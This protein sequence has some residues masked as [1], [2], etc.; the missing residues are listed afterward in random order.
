VN[1]LVKVRI[2]NRWAWEAK[3]SDY[4]YHCYPQEQGH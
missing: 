4:V 2:S 1:V 3:I